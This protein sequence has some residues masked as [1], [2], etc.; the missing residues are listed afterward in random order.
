MQENNSNPRNA[1]QPG[2]E[3]L[4]YKVK[5]VLGQGAFGITYLAQDI[6]LNRLVAIKEFLPG[7][8]AM[9]DGNETVRPVS[10]DLEEKFSW[11]LRRFIEEARILDQ[12]EH[13][14]IVRVMNIF[15][16]NNTA[17]MV[18][19]YE[20]GVSL[21][22]ILIRQKFLDES[23]LLNI[24][25]P[26][27]DGLEEIHEAGFIHRD[28]KPANIFIRT[29]G[30]PV[31]LDFGSA[32]QSLEKETHTLTSLVSPGYAPIEQYVSK[33]DKQGPW[34]DIYGMAA[35]LYRTVTGVPPNDAITRGESLTGNGEDNLI[36]CRELADKRYSDHFIAAI[37]H[38]LKFLTRDRP[39]TIEEWKEEFLP[40]AG[41]GEP[42]ST[43]LSGHAS[44]Q[45]VSLVKESLT[46]TVTRIHDDSDLADY[47]DKDNSASVEMAHKQG[48]QHG[49]KVALALLTLIVSGLFIGN[50]QKIQQVVS[51]GFVP[52]DI[53]SDEPV[54]MVQEE[55]IIQAEPVEVEP[56]I[57]ESTTVEPARI[58]PEKDKPVVRIN[59]PEVITE[60][61]P[62]VLDEQTAAELQA[63][64]KIIIVDEV[65]NNDSL[66]VITDEGEQLDVLTGDELLFEDLPQE[67]IS[68]QE[69]ILDNESV[70]ERNGV[71]PYPIQDNR[72]FK[73][74]YITNVDS[75]STSNNKPS[76]S[77]TSNIS[78]IAIQE[79]YV[80]VRQE[81]PDDN[82]VDRFKNWVE[83]MVT[84]GESPGHGKE[85]KDQPGGQMLEK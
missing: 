70:I 51:P 68:N 85:P 54:E 34:S 41:T 3:L 59:E 29:D 11:G 40:L 56:A 26:V 80:P 30:T 9:R 74:P 12:F 35:T 6:N 20:Q 21:K 50:Y 14:N 23:D 62:Q 71:S 32:R 13:S 37:E 31:L 47:W 58:E 49:L 69:I 4:W 65:G 82:V 16:A 77:E 1:L 8:Y 25:F 64:G 76:N 2:Y 22:E 19:R 60:T 46:Q 18:M 10:E 24:L 78:D 55:E 57:V 38:G 5:S 73:N 43:V 27:L 45:V 36:S 61:S 83:L 63:E 66:N 42:S 67:E 7:Q 81:D 33:S 15:E 79:V 44:S 84:T 53:I 39:Q 52:Q 75:A 48:F 17:Y 72:D 28:I